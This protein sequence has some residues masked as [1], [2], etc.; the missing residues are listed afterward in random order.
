[1]Q[2]ELQVR[3]VVDDQDEL[4]RLP[5]LSPHR[6]DGLPDVVPAFLGVD[7]DDDGGSHAAPW[8]AADGAAG[9]ARGAVGLRRHSRK[10]VLSTRMPSRTAR[11]LLCP[12]MRPC[13]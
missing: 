2:L 12:K 1:L 10:I 8:S 4:V 3:V 6:L 5:P 7:A 11:R 9:S 13:S